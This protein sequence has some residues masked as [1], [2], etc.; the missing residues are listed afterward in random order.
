MSSGPS[1]TRSEFSLYDPIGE[2]FFDRGYPPRESDRVIFFHA[3]GIVCPTASKDT[4]KE[5]YLN[6]FPDDIK[7][8]YS[9]STIPKK[10]ICDVKKP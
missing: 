4:M 3:V 8:W 7:K 2:L 1:Y 9:K 5:V 6:R 10:L